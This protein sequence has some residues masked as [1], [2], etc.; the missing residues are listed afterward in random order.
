MTVIF[1]FTPCK[2][3]TQ[4][5]AYEKFECG[6]Q[7]ISELQFSWIE[8]HQIAL[9]WNTWDKA[10]KENGNQTGPWNTWELPLF[11]SSES[12]QSWSF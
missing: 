12:W 10:T 3:N 8:G 9:V 7:L 11:S 2:S 4:D 6:M 1:I 5:Q